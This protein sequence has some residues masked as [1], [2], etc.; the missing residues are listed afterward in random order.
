M[1]WCPEYGDT[2]LS[3]VEEGDTA[4]AR[5]SSCLIEAAWGHTEVSSRHKARLR[6]LWYWPGGSCLRCGTEAGHQ[7]SHPGPQTRTRYHH[8]H[9]VDILSAAARDTLRKIAFILQ[10]VWSVQRAEMCRA[11]YRCT[12]CSALVCCSSTAAAT[13]SR[14]SAVQCYFYFHSHSAFLH[15]ALYFGHK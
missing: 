13:T 9:I 12:L 1:T 10:L 14:C 3:V 7:D 8:L 15:S 2:G 6:M 5:V 4:S 11:Q